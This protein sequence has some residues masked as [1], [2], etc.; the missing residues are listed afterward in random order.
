MKS[1]KNGKLSETI[2]KRSVLRPMAKQNTDL[3]CG[4]AIGGDCAVFSDFMKEEECLCSCVN[5]VMGD[6]ESLGIHA[7]YSAVN[8][9]AAKGAKPK[10]ILTALTLPEEAS[11]QEL[12][13]LMEQMVA[14]AKE[15]GVTLSGGHTEINSKVLMP[16]ISVTGIGTLPKGWK[17]EKVKPG[18]DIVITKWAG[19]AGTALIAREREDDLLQRYPERFLDEAI[20]LEKHLSVVPEA[21]VATMSGVCAMH[22]ASRGGIFAALWELG[23]A[24]GV[25][26]EVDLK[27]IPIKQ[28]TIEVCDFFD[29]NPYELVSGGALVIATDNGYGLVRELEKN[30]IPAAVVGKI[31]DNNDRVVINEEERRFLEPSRTDG[32]YKVFDK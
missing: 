4:A 23:E 19:I 30:K 12:R 5:T 9:L 8:N 18:Q 10:T 31:T 26:L 15:A 17:N 6:M 22:D 3:L 29:V 11:E 7:V 32:I 28:E 2:L 25:G 27:K 16:I 24:H 21:A 14:A 13:G 1:L 20:A